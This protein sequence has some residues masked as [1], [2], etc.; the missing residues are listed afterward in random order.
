[1]AWRVLLG[2]A[3]GIVDVKIDAHSGMLPGPLP[4]FNKP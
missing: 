4:R 3:S 2:L 1:V